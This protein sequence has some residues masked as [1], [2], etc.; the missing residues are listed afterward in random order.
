MVDPGIRGDERCQAPSPGG[1]WSGA[2]GLDRRHPDRTHDRPDAGRQHQPDA[3]CG[4]PEVGRD[5]EGA[6]PHRHREEGLG[7][8]AHGL[9]DR[10]PDDDP[11]RDPDHRHLEGH[12]DRSERE[13][14]ARHTERHA[15]TDLAPLGL[16][17]AAGQVERGEGGTGQDQQREDGEEHLIVLDVVVELAVPAFLLEEADLGRCRGEGGGEGLP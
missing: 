17:D 10:V 13:P 11:G 15:H 7:D 5:L 12:E 2:D 9:A 1:P 8:V 16:D 14:G 4:G 6:L 3:Q